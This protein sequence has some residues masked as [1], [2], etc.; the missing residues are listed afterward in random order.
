MSDAVMNDPF[1]DPADR[2]EFYQDVPLKRLIAWAVDF[3]A[4]LVLTAL[5]VPLTGFTALFF[6][7]FLYL[8]V[9]FVYRAW[10]LSS[11]S[12]TPGMRLMTM[13]IR[14]ADAQPLDRTTALLHTL[15]FVLSFSMVVPQIISVAM[16]ILSPRRQGLTD[17]VLGTVAINR[18][19]VTKY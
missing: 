2:P 1:P 15:G 4:T 6:L 19:A 10:S 3:A 17:F 16:M 7:P 18:A 5:V 12:A 9:N 13:E 8:V 14:D 11:R